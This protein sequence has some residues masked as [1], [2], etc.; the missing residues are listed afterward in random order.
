M[1]VLPAQD[2]TGL[3]RRLSQ[4][5]TIAAVQQLAAEHFGFQLSDLL[6]GGRHRTHLLAR[7]T[8]MWAARTYLGSSLKELGRAFKADHTTVINACR[9]VEWLRDDCGWRFEPE[10][11]VRVG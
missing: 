9:R 3:V 7:H 8:A 1:P 5:R 6:Y 11:R 10:P 2:L 4:Q